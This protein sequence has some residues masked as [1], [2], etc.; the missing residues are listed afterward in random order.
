MM[1][2]TW[3]TGHA[4]ELRVQEWGQA[5]KRSLPYCPAHGDSQRD[6][7]DAS[8]HSPCATPL[9]VPPPSIVL[10]LLL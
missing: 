4:S 2:F 5:G 1:A 6:A 3:G 7:L 8:E 9:H 10:T